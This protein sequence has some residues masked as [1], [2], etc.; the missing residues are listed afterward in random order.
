MV[1]NIVAE[2]G[3]KRREISGMYQIYQFL[4][5]VLHTWNTQISLFRDIFFLMCLFISF[6]N[7]PTES[8]H[9]WGGEQQQHHIEKVPQQGE[10]QAWPTGRTQQISGPSAPEDGKWELLHN[11]SNPGR[12][13]LPKFM[14][15]MIPFSSYVN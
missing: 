5:F 11:R 10:A 6:D 14:H 7:C 1:C 3:E 12:L 2:G 4:Y 8:D 13:Y 9:V 15:P